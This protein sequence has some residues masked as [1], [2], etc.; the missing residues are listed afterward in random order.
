MTLR[1]RSLLLWDGCLCVYG[2][3]CG[4]GASCAGGAGCRVRS[5]KFRCGELHRGQKIAPKNSSKAPTLFQRNPQR[6][7]LK[8]WVTRRPPGIRHLGLLNSRSRPT[9]RGPQACLPASSRTFERMLAP[10]VSTNPDAVALCSMTEFG[11][12]V[13]PGFF[14][15]PKCKAGSVI[16]KNKV[17]VCVE[18]AGVLD[19]CQSKARSTT[20]FSPRVVASLFRSCT[21]LLKSSDTPGVL[22]AYVDRRSMSNGAPNRREPGS[23]LSR[24][25]R[26]QCLSGMLPLISSILILDGNIG[27][28]GMVDSSPTQVTVPARAAH[29]QYCDARFA[30]RRKSRTRPIRRRSAPKGVLVEPHYSSSL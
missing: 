5:G 29:H 19:V 4:D 2:R 14:P 23:R 15:A 12:A 18:A 27:N 9:G 17:V 28:T 25:L 24:L 21:Y 22:R 1:V 30:L 3:L 7:R 8:R 10:G 26:N 16:G 6:P 20:S 13:A 11:E